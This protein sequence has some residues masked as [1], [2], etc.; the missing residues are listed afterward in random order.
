MFY[1]SK[2]FSAEM[3]LWTG[4]DQGILETGGP[5]RWRSPKPSAEGASA[6]G[7]PPQKILKN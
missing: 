5:V 4:A 2:D 7:G 1:E 3:V 6:G